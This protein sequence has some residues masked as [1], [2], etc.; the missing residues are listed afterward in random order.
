MGRR[1]GFF[2]LLVLLFPSCMQG[3]LPKRYRTERF[4]SP[5]P[6]ANISRGYRGSTS[7]T[8]KPLWLH[9]IH[10]ATER[11]GV[12]NPNRRQKGD[13]ETVGEL[14]RIR[15]GAHA[16]RAQIKLP[17]ELLRG[18]LHIIVALNELFMFL[19]IL[20]TVRWSLSASF[21]GF[22]MDLFVLGGYS[23]LHVNLIKSIWLEN[24]FN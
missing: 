10:C 24:S 9:A 4:L 14:R 8:T 20:H 13:T 7:A 6:H 19:C 16:S 18:S 21:F 23:P 2:P 3:A 11:V 22:L 1:V 12:S 15:G 17:F 5:S